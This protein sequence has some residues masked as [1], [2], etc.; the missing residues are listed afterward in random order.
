MHNYQKDIFLHFLDRE[1]LETQGVYNRNLETAIFRDIRFLILNC[2]GSLILSAS[3]LFESMYA[4]AVLNSFLPFFSSGKFTVAITYS[5]I[6]KMVAVK[7]DQ[8]KGK[9]HL[10]PNYFNDLQHII[11]ESGL[12]VVPK[13]SD[14]TTFIAEGMVNDISK[15]RQLDNKSNIPYLIE[16][17]EERGKLAITHHLFD[18]VYDRRNVSLH[19][20][21]SV[22]EAIS[23]YYIKAYTDYFDATIPKGLTCGVY[24]YD[25]LADD[26]IISDVS[27]WVQLY[28]R[29]GLYNFVCNSSVS[30]L[31]SISEQIDQLRFVSVVSNWI[32]NCFVKSD[33]QCTGRAFYSQ[34]NMIPK[35]KPVDVDN[36]YQYIIRINEVSNIL[37]GDQVLMHATE[38]RI[39][40]YDRRKTVFVVHGR[41]ERLK[42]D[43]FSFLRAVGITPLEWEEAVSL[44]NKGTPTTLEVITAGMNHSSGIV[45]L[46][47]GDDY[48]KLRDELCKPGEKNEFEYQP[49]PNVLFEAGMA[50]ALFPN[51]C[52]LVRVGELREISDLSGVNYVNLS[53][54]SV[55]RQAFVT[56]LNTI[57][58]SPNCFGGDWLSIGDF[59]A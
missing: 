19:D 57:G 29:I 45:I 28:K 2:S 35:M 14:T 42:R 38:R 51:S 37:N 1:L 9:E 13:R 36:V 44:T 55:D 52:L 49:R 53:N 12:V 18:R 56:R 59:S 50:M 17:I 15:G 25:Y 10:F 47:T 4:Y 21:D 39:L 23:E 40:M 20:R 26:S 11:A 5:G 27:F 33:I 54:N 16:T 6:K 3:F 7:Q 22:N 24:Q 8:Y 43:L 32:E 41:N 58:L 46:F 34:V 30:S 48:V 31:L